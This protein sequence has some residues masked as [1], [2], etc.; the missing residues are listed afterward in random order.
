M[1]PVNNNLTKKQDFQN[2]V[3]IEMGLHG[4]LQISNKTGNKHKKIQSMENF[5][6]F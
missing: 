4:K 6:L 2:E 5:F 1:G 3:Q